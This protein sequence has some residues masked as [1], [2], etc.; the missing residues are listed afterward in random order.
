MCAFAGLVIFCLVPTTLGIGVALV[1]SCKGNEGVALLLT[2]GSNML[3]VVSAI[4]ALNE[5][6]AYSP[7]SLSHRHTYMH[8]ARGTN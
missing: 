2:V 8:T 5:Q 6:R 7:C 4:L 1:R 3:G